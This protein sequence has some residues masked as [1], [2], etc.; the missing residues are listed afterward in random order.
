MLFIITTAQIIK[1]NGTVINGSK[2]IH[3]DLT[4]SNK[5]YNKLC[6]MPSTDTYPDDIFLP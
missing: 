6:I 1:R 4:I 2:H 3:V 5:I